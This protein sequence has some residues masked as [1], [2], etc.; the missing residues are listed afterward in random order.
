MIPI[1]STGVTSQPLPKA[2]Q[3][4]LSLL[5]RLRGREGQVALYEPLVTAE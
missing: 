5:P 1:G 4:K 2:T 3:I